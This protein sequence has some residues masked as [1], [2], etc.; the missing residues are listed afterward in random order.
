MNKSVLVVGATGVAGSAFV[1]HVRE[2]RSKGECNWEL[3]GTTRQVVKDE[4]FDKDC[5]GISF[6]TADF[7]ADCS[8]VKQLSGITHV[9]F[10]GFVPAPGF[11]Q[12]VIPNR[13]LLVNCLHAL[14]NNPL[15]RIVLIQGMKYY[16][17]HLGPFKT[18]A[19]EDDPRHDGANYYYAQ[20]DVLEQSGINWTCLRP[21]VICGTASMGTPQNILGVIGVYASL[22][23]DRNLPLSWP[24]TEESFM[25]INQATDARLLASAIAWS[26]DSEEAVNQAYNVTNGDFFR[27][28]HLWPRIAELFAM[29]R[30][31]VCP[32][33]LS[34][35]MPPLAARWREIAELHGL[36]QAS[37]NALVN[38][39]FADYIMGTGWDVMASTVKIRQSGF[40]ECM[41]TESMYLEHLR[42]LADERVLPVF[43]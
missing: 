31:E 25:S 15:R 18:P 1:Q 4:S 3:T 10:A 12:Q 43:L 13:D 11:D 40:S 8:A 28:Q 37:M 34:N 23:R 32:R 24:G 26:L 29:E 17:S 41:D 2:A 7:L 30:G 14:D 6:V 27:W 38:W 39:S 19:R 21:H 36:R 42:K 9:V 5:T 33:Q 35:T 16:G 20:Q 22:M